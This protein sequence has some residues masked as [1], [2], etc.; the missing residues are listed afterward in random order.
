[1]RFVAVLL[2]IG[3]LCPA[4][5]MAAG[6]PAAPPKIVAPLDGAT[7]SRPVVVQFE[8]GAP[9]ARPMAMSGDKT[10]PG[11]RHVHL[12]I[13][14]DPPTPGARVPVD[15]RHRHFMNGETSASLTLARGRQPLRLRVA[16][17]QHVVDAPPVVSAPVTITVK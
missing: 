3:L 16:N 15:A 14:A 12:L 7:V 13:D 6:M 1:M 11:H 8:A 4:A 5:G 17:G 10:M 2:A 9:D